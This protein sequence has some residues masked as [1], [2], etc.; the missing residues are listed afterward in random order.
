M[1]GERG[2]WSKDCFF[3]WAMR[4]PL[5]VKL[6]RLSGGRRISSNVSLIDLLPTL[7]DLAEIDAAELSEPPA[8][9]SLIGLLTD[10]EGAWP[11]RVLAEYTAEAAEAPMVMIRQ[12]PY[13]YIQAEGDPPLLYDM[14]TDPDEL[15]NLAK[16]PEQAIRCSDFAQEVAARWNLPDLDSTIRLSQRRRALVG[17][18]LARGA[19]DHWDYEPQPDYS[20]IY[21]RTASGSELA[22]RRI[23]LPAKGYDLPGASENIR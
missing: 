10:T 21:V 19:R 20:K 7:L 1:L 16:D 8:G 13:K 12:G 3:E 6:P 9:Q 18:A 14:A 4:I 15:Q 22:D 23:R 17:D 2:L 11:D 5:L